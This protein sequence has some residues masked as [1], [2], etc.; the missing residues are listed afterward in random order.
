MLIDQYDLRKLELTLLKMHK[1]LKNINSLDQL[2]SI[3]D[4][5]SHLNRFMSKE[6]ALAWHLLGALQGVAIIAVDDKCKVSYAN[7]YARDI[8]GLNIKQ[9]AAKT[10]QLPKAVHKRIVTE[11]KKSSTDF[12]LQ[13]AVGDELRT[14]KVFASHNTAFDD[15]QSGYV[16]HMHDIS[17]RVSTEL[18][19]RHTEQFLRHLIDASPDIICFKDEKSRWLEA[20]TSSIELFQLD[21]K[22]YQ[23]KTDSELANQSDPVFKEAFHHSKISDDQAWRLGRAV[24]NEE[25]ISL[26]HG[27][28]KVLDV[29]KVPLFN[30]NGSRHGLVTLGRDITERKM[31]ESH[32]RDRSAILDALISC[33]WLLHS[34]ESWHSVAVMVLQQLCL[35]LRFTRA[36]ILMNGD[37]NQTE[38]SKK[39]KYTHS[40]MIYKWSVP[41]LNVPE[42][43]LEAIDFNHVNL[44]RWKD[45]LQLGDPVFGDIRDLP[46]SE[47][48]LLEQQDTKSIAIVPLFSDKV[49]WGNIIIERCHDLIKTTPQ[50]LGSLMAIGRSLGVAIQRESAGKRLHQAKI[51]FDSASEGTLITDSKLR[52]VAINKGYTEIT[53]YT[54][55]EV[56]GILPVFLHSGNHNRRFYKEI[57]SI[58]KKEGR[59]HGEVLNKR[60]SG[61]DFY[62]RLTI[63]AVHDNAG[64]VVNY[65]G[66]FADITD[67][68]QSQIK[69]HELVNHDPLTG[70]PN[71][72][73]L[74]ELLEHS[75]KRAERNKL[76][77]GL[78]FIDLDRFKAVN[79]SLGHQV[80]DKLLLEVSKRISLSM[81]ESDVVARLGGDEFVVLMDVISNP[82]DAALVAKK[83]IHALQIQFYIDGNEIYIGASIGI[84]IFPKDSDNVEGLIKAADIAMY[85]VKNKGKNGHCFYSDELSKKAVERFN[86]EG[87]LRHALE[88]KQFEVYYQPQ[89][90]LPSGDIIGA[91]ALI[92][93]NHPQLGLIS[94]ATFIPL[95]EETG[96][97][98]PIGEWVL[99]EVA[100]QVMRWH[101]QGFS[102]RWVSVNVSG[103]QI[104]RS[105]FADT[106]YSILMESDCNPAMLELEITESTV[107]HN[108]EFVIDTFNRIK[109]LGLRLAIDD[110]GTGYSS[111]AH[112]KRLPLDKIKIDQSFVRDLP[113]DLD[114]AAIANAIYAMARSLGFGVIAE[115][116]ETIAQADFL[117]NMGCEEGQG[118]LYSKPVTATE[119]S[120]LL[121]K[122]Q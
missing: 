78:L 3:P 2:P 43:K 88:R 27:G 63:T 93:W 62:E 57:W 114:D 1:S 70:L 98:V 50:E 14:L 44:K 80:G 11:L 85:Q 30:D 37:F 121:E 47:R 119:F 22:N 41:G 9:V 52:I 56:L 66:V 103:I 35:A 89:V 108:T 25:V 55:D 54:E 24:R 76:N 4:S 51:A 115:G 113:E 92:R 75:I 31:A 71:R 38:I 8:F 72:R 96:L 86:L 34:A 6:L 99:R 102:I 116:I 120:K 49:W 90:S 40:K 60:K 61:E 12:V 48:Q 107:M 10:G 105:N 68:K 33:D 28:E 87:Q 84:S 101:N 26:P 20:N 42:K 53:G 77:V 95:A 106:V 73:L 19:L 59:W 23:L 117:S 104:M 81:R 122:Q 118:Y 83:I 45:A 109:Q 16:L 29:I 112:L 111:L 100:F 79:D 67:I 58:L 91:E 15:L 94:P 69:L 32:L 97:I 64:E 17:D 82:N 46:S 7:P 65:V 74:N 21:Q 18:Q 36:T 5:A 13:Y 110:F 39:A